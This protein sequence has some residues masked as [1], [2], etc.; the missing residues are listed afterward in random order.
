MIAAEDVHQR[1]FA[2]AVLADQADGA[3]CVRRESSRRAALARRRNLCGC[4]GTQASAC[5][6]ASLCRAASST[7]ASRMTAPFTIM[8][9]KCERF[10]RFS[11]LSIS[12]RKEH[13]EDGP[14]HFAFAAEKTGAA[15]DGRA[16][17]IE[18][19]ALAIV[20]EPVSRR[21]GVEDRGDG[22]AKPADNVGAEG[23]ARDGHAG[24]VGR[25]FIVPDRVKP[26]A[27]ERAAQCEM[28]EHSD[29]RAPPRTPE[30]PVRRSR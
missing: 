13:A 29:D 9:V 28:R 23:D 30:A 27:K 21:P 12:V 17:D 25:A 14:E 8:M 20:G 24:D 5:L 16:D 22:R 15:D 2:R 6:P 7:A 10:W 18:Q 19:N 1:R 11:V 3:P 26:A 4:F